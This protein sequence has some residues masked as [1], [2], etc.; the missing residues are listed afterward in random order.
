M[1]VH[2]FQHVA[3]EGPGYIATWMQE[4]GHVLSATRFFE[5]GYQ[6]PDPATLDALVVMGGPMSVYD[7]AVYA[8]LQEEKA[9]IKAMIQAG[10]KVL[11][12]CLGSQLAALC[13]GAT[14]SRAPHQEIGWYPVFAATT[15][16]EPAP[17]IYELLRQ[18]PHV[19]HWHGDQFAIP[20]D[21]YELAFSAA[22]RNQGFMYRD[23]V[24]GLQF[25]AEPF[26]ADLALMLAHGGAE[27]KADT[28]VQDEQGI[29]AELFRT[30]DNHQLMAGLLQHFFYGPL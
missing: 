21:A 10:K 29:T 17:G 18:G 2:F 20:Q 14:V 23:Q 11:G 13:L 6:L 15:A 12:I 30:G 9:F 3:F 4:Q 26:A 22:N 7:D 1:R 16:E 25:H 27:L 5:P 19:F 24:M 8:W 28:Y